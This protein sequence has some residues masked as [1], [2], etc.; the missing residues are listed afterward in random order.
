MAMMIVQIAS[1]IGLV[2]DVVVGK[3]RV[4]V[5]WDGGRGDR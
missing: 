1:P 2:T 3:E 4:M 5:I